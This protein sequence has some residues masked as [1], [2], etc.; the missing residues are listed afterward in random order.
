[1]SEEILKEA[2]NKCYEKF[3]YYEK[4]HLDKN[5]QESYEKALVNKDMQN[6]IKEAL[7]KYDKEK[8]SIKKEHHEIHACFSHDL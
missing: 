7:E 2:L 4:C 1:M 3:K 5:T 6:M 8:S